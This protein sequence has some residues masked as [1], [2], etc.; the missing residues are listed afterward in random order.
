MLSGSLQ[1]QIHQ[2]PC[3]G[4]QFSQGELAPAKVIVDAGGENTEL[5]QRLEA[6]DY[7]SKVSEP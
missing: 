1:K 5:K 4:E 6:L 7:V 2:L 3:I